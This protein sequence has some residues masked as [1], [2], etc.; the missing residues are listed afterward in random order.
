MFGEYLYVKS[1]GPDFVHATQQNAAP[2]GQG[3]VPFGTA[4]NLIQPWTGAFRVGGGYACSDCS[5]IQV[6][7]TQFASHTSDTLG[8]PGGTNTGSV[9]S[10][11]LVPGTINAGT[12]FSQVN[13]TSGVNFKTAD[14]M[15]SRLLSGGDNHYINYQVGARYAHLNQGFFQDAEFA[16]PNNPQFTTANINFDGV[17][18][19][20]GLDGRRRIGCGGL[21]CYGKSFV[22]VLFGDFN[23]FYTQTDT[24]TTATLAANNWKVARVVP[25]LEYELGLSWTSCN[26]CWR[27][28]AAT[29]RLSGSTRS[30]IRSTSRPCRATISSS[31]ATR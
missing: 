4:Q 10:S 21:S 27:A 6:A 29:T 22:S 13:A 23:S 16:Q 14:I 12:T 28:S 2:A 5:S 30:P 3:T 8:L 17:G 9:I 26:G 25:I 7:Y 11:V 18:S 31:W 15:Y 24:L 20:T 1:Y 19:R